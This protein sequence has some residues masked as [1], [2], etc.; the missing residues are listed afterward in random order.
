MRVFIVG[1]NTRGAFQFSAF[2]KAIRAN[3]GVRLRIRGLLDSLHCG[4]ENLATL[5]DRSFA[6]A[7]ELSYA[8]PALTISSR[9]E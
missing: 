9:P 7:G 4:I 6:L 5:H 3:S 8:A 2:M 1:L